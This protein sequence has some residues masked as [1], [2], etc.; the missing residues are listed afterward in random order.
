MHPYV[1]PVYFACDGGLAYALGTAGKKIEW[2]R[3]NPKVCLL[4]DDIESGTDWISVIALGRYRELAEPRFAEEREHARDLLKQR[5]RWWTPA[6]AERQ[7]KSNSELIYPIFFCIEIEVVSGL[8]SMK[9]GSHNDFSL[10]K[11]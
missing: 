8:R 4:V 5:S 9:E 10:R 1:V 6:L 2:M 3:Q 11:V 7:L